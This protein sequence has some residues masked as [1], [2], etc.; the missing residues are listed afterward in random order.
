MLQYRDICD[1][2]LEFRYLA[3][4]PCLGLA[5]LG[6]PSMLSFCSSYCS[7]SSLGARRIIDSL[8]SSSAI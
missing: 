4:G 8:D 5:G 1:D 2:I 3:G 7:S 6:D